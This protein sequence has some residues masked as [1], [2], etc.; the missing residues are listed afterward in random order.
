MCAL[1]VLTHDIIYGRATG[2]GSGSGSVSF[3][4]GV[5][6]SS[7]AA[8][9][10]AGSRLHRNPQQLISVQEDFCSAKR[11]VATAPATTVIKPPSSLIEYGSMVDIYYY[12]LKNSSIPCASPTAIAAT[13]RGPHV[14]SLL[15]CSGSSSLHTGC[16]IALSCRRCSLPTLPSGSDM[17]RCPSSSRTAIQCTP[18]PVLESVF[19]IMPRR[20]VRATAG[21]VSLACTPPHREPYICLPTRSSCELNV[22]SVPSSR[23]ARV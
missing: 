9:I 4:G 11:T 8:A 5:T 21:S 17:A 2:S 12:S 7:R 19:T 18:E 10:R 13:L 6:L 14:S 3:W 1:F 23:S 16:S 15:C 22:R 20:P